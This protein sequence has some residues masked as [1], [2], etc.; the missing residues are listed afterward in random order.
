VRNLH[1]KYAPNDAQ[2]SCGDEGNGPTPPVSVTDH[3]SLR[4]A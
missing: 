1:A 3:V 2:D 4:I